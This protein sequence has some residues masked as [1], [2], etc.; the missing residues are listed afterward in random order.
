MVKSCGS[1][2]VSTYGPSGVKV[3]NDLQ[4]AHWLSAF[5]IVRSLMS[6]DAV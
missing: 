1:S 3:S 4:R 5:W 2:F 6:C